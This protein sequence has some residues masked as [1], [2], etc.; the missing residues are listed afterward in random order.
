MDATLGLMDLGAVGMAATG[1]VIRTDTLRRHAA[2]AATELLPVT[3]DLSRFY[4][5]R[6]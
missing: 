4:R 1:T 6:P 2:Q 3:N 5:L